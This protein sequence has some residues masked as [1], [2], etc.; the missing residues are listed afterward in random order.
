MPT[1]VN[2]RGI[3]MGDALGYLFEF[4]TDGPE[5]V[6]D[7]WFAFTSATG[8]QSDKPYFLLWWGFELS[9]AAM[10]VAWLL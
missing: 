10:F 5:W 6:Q 9:V 2:S 8:V 3:V 1:V 4:V 7:L